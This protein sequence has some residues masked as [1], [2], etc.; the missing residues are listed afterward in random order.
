MSELNPHMTEEM[1]LWINRLTEITTV[2]AVS[3][4]ES[5]DKMTCYQ[6]DKAVLMRL[7]AGYRVPKV[8]A[9]S[10]DEV[11]ARRKKKEGEDRDDLYLTVIVDLNTRKVIWVSQGRKKRALD[12]F[13]ELLG[14]EACEE[15]RVVAADQHRGYADSVAIN[16]PK[17]TLVWD[18]FHLV[19]NFNDALNEDRKLELLDQRKNSEARR[20]LQGRYRYIF[21]TKADHRS[22]E[23]QRHIDAIMKRNEKIAKM[24]LIK[25]H[26][27]KVFDCESEEDAQLM[28]A[29]CYQWALDVKAANIFRFIRDL[30]HERSFLNYFKFKVTTSVSEGINRVIKGMKW[31]AYGYRDMF[32]F[33]LKILQKCGYLNSQF[34]GN[35]CPN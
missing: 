19:Q 18:R 24:E 35:P 10:V 30:R 5:I 25:E 28:M 23:D 12:E 20:L 8:T 6:V 32:Y 4:L 16:C 14:K 11:Y 33:A 29:E 7:L 26:F 27:H 17:A 34:A 3:R 15:I 2:L 22:K 9:I 31:M 13:F 1:A 21:L